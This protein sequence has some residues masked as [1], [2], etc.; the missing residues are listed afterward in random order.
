MSAL[1]LAGCAFVAAGALWATCVCRCRARQQKKMRLLIHNVQKRQNIGSLVRVAVAM[2]CEEIVLV[3][4]T[5][6]R[7][8]GTFGAHGTNKHIPF[9]HYFTLAEARAALKRDAFDVVGVEIMPQARNV[10]QYWP[11][12]A[13]LGIVRHP[14]S[15][16][17][18]ICVVMGNEGHG[19]HETLKAICDSFLYIPQYSQGTASLNV[20]T[21][22]AIVMSH[23]ALYRCIPEAAREGE[24]YVVD[25]PPNGREQYQ[26]DP[27]LFDKVRDER[28]AKATAAEDDDCADDV[29]EA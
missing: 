14:F 28:S 1:R 21:A 7:E 13:G 22:A 2:R 6:R 10:A 17:R 15:A 27:S 19:I 3:S 4:K 8:F 20:C 16:S 12:L 5:D 25:A 24:K 18:N 9:K 23:I 29:F 11:L 26:A